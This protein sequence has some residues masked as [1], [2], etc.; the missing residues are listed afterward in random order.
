MALLRVAEKPGPKGGSRARVRLRAAAVALLLSTAATA[1]PLRAEGPDGAPPAATTTARPELELQIG[2]TG[3]VNRVVYS[4]DGKLL[5][6]ASED[7]TVKL[8]DIATGTLQQTLTGHGGPVETMAF[9]PDSQTL[10]SGDV[11]GTIRLWDVAAGAPFWVFALAENVSAVAFSPD[12]RLLVSGGGDGTIRFWDVARRDEVRE[13]VHQRGATVSLAFSPDGEALAGGSADGEL[14]VWDV[15]TGRS[16]WTQPVAVPA[17]SVRS[18]AFSPDGK[19]VVSASGGSGKSGQIRF[20]NARTGEPLQTLPGHQTPTVGVTFA[21]LHQIALAFSPTGDFIVGQ[22][23]H[24]ALKLWDVAT[25]RVVR[26]L[27]HHEGIN[28]V[29]F[30]PDGRTIATGAGVGSIKLWDRQT[31]SLHWTQGRG[32]GVLTVAVSPDGKALASGY[33]DKSVRIWDCRTG[34]LLRLLAGHEG[35]VVSVA[36]SPDSKLLASGSDDGTVKLWEV[37]KGTGLQS[38]KCPPGTQ[39]SVAFA[40]DGQRLAVGG[41]TGVAPGHVQVW[42]VRAGTPLWSQEG[43]EGYVVSVAFSP[44]GETVASTGF[45]RRVRLWD[46]RTGATLHQMSGHTNTVNAVSFSPDGTKLASGGADLSVKVWDRQTGL[47]LRT[48]E[49]PHL[50]HNTHSLAFSPDGMTLATAAADRE[51]KLWDLETGNLRRSLTGHTH[52]VS[53][54]AFTPDGKQIISGSWDQAIKIWHATNGSLLATLLILPPAQE[55]A[56]ASDWLVVT[57]EG[58]YDGS[59]GAARFIRWRVGNDRFPVEAYEQTFHRPDL[60]RKLLGGEAFRDAPEVRRFTA[61]QAIPP[62]VAFTQP[63]HGQVVSGDS[64]AVS[65]AVTDDREVSRVELSVNGRPVEAKPILLGAKPIS[66]VEKPIL[67]G[68]KPVPAPHR[69]LFEYQATVPLP[70]GESRVKLRAVAHDD[71]ALQ[72]WTEIQLVRSLP[73]A[74]GKPEEVLGDL[75]VLSVGVSR[76]RDPRH[77]LKYAA[78]D[79]DAFARLWQ[80]MEGSLYRRVLVTPLTDSQATAANVRAAL[81]KLLETAS[82]RDSVAL[83]LS[84]HGVQAGAGKFYFATHE[85]DVASPQRLEQTALPWTVFETTLAKVDAKRVLL[86]LDAC[87]SGSVL[88][89]QQATNERLA[90]ALAKRGGVLVFTSS[91]GNEVSYEEASL[92]HGAFTAALLEGIGQGKAD[93]AVGG[94]PDGKISTAELLTY[95]QAR[96]PQMT[97]NRQTPAC[98]LL[99]DFGE[100]FLVAQRQ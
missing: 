98:P 49:P 30:S 42:D 25:G 65:L 67:I 23:F 24:G 88:G 89:E 81:F 61:G 92:G 16:R 56:V 69:K 37:T 29:A 90:E 34:A 7:R 21:S 72:G 64:V 12:G 76:Y 57:P 48:F 6:S 70:P 8:W 10:I 17:R 86:F 54:V 40:P 99:A 97:G 94:E 2:H 95:L 50:V 77:H 43:L 41:G 18:L 19:S 4:P 44:D 74:T 96:V 82:N 85:I 39:A 58:Y 46:A 32:D 80:R 9:S 3:P 35:H 78:A 51:V 87:H 84:G 11:D 52:L 13:P 73:F 66:L 5:A 83:F 71:E 63:A 68:G 53:T 60:V 45:D 55:D 75:H 62:L 33:R 26:T 1:L 47:L 31:G 20:W 93:L 79:A 91:R 28:S 36:F 38:L 22:S 59:P 27:D 14:R 15:A 100:A